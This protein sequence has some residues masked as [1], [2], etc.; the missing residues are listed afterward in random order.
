MNAQSSAY[1][2]TKSKS[3][4]G[5][6]PALYEKALNIEHK[7]ELLDRKRAPNLLE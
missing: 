5:L 4:E 3:P 7:K 6:S 2:S 1:F